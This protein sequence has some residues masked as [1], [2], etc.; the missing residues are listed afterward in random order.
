M[1]NPKLATLVDPFTGAS[2][3]TG[4]WSNITG[5]TATLD[6]TNDLVVLAQ[7]TV[8]GTTNTFGSNTLYDATASSI[9][10]EVGTVANGSGQ[11][12]TIFKILL[13]ANNSVAM[14][15][16]AGVFKFTMQIAGVTTTTTLPT[17]DP[18]AHGWWRLRES[19]GSFFADVSSDGFTW[20][21]LTSSTYSWSAVAVTFVFQTS[22]GGT[23]VAGNS[24]TIQHVNTMLGGG[25]AT[26]WNINWPLLEEAWAPQWNAAGGASPLDRYVDVTDRTRQQSTVSRG[27]Q[28]EL[29]QVR[30]GEA[31]LE[32]ENLDGV[33]DPTNSSGP[34]FNSI[35]PFQP[36]RKRAQWPRTRNLL[37]QMQATAGDL[38]GQTVGATAGSNSSDVF[39]T[40][41]SG[42]GTIVSTASAWQG[43]TVY[44]FAVTSAAT[45][46]QGICYTMQPAVEPGIQYTVSLWVRNV[47]AS[48]SLQ[49]QAFQ[50]SVAIGGARTNTT[51]TATTLTG[52][53]TA[54]WTQVTVT[55]TATST[56]SSLILG[57]QVVTAPGSTAQ[58]QVDGWQLEKAATASTWACPGVWYP[59]FAGFMER[60]PSQ[61]A[62]SG[63]YGTVQP[64][65]VDAMALLS[66]VTLKDPLAQQ[67]NG[68][69][70][71]FLYT[72][73]DPQSSSYA[74][75]STGQYGPAP[76]A[77][78][79]Y[80]SGSVVFGTQI[81]S[82][83]AGGTY[84]GASGTVATVNN[85]NPGSGAINAATW[86]S[87]SGAGVKGPAN[88]SLW[89]RMIA[90]RY[91]GPTPG[92]GGNFATIWT[93]MDGQRA[94][95]Q[96]S[97]SQ[98]W[99]YIDSTGR[100]NFQLRGPTGT[101]QTWLFGS[102]AN[103]VDSNWHLL[104]FGY[105]AA[106][107]EMLMSLDGGLACYAGGL[108]AGLAPTGLISDCVGAYVDPTDGNGTAGNFKGDLSYA[109]E[110]PIEFQSADIT[111]MY[112]AWKSS[113]TGDSTNARYAR[114]LSYAGYTGL[115]SLQ[116][117][118][119]TS[120]GPMATGG[121]DGLSALQAV[122]DTENGEHYVARDGTV[123]FKARSA[124]YNATVPA[125]VFGE[126]TDLGEIPY[127]DC[128]LDFDSTHLANL[129]QVTQ[130]STNQVFTAQDSTSQTNYFPRTLTRSINPS[131]ALEC[132]D[133][134]NYLVSRYKNP[135]TRVS[136][137]VLHPSANPQ[138]W[139]MCLSLELGMRVR[140]NRR[141]PSPAA[142]ISVDCFVENLQWSNDSQGEAQLT[143]QCSPIDSTPY[144]ILAA[145][146]TT[147]NTTVLSGVNTITINNSADNTNK[148]AAQIYPGLQ[149]MFSPGFSTQE[150]LTV[151]SVG[152]TSPGWTTATIVF[153]TNLA[154]GHISGETICEVLP[155]GVTDATTYDNNAK[156]DSIAFAY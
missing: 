57:V 131:S 142:A 15:L 95:N 62:M 79:K 4:L 117:G 150:T 90:V 145:W 65:A 31:S 139:P 6:Q 13:D 86:V 8:S 120:M 18:N 143:L 125:Y 52:S 140:V 80:G 32:L 108:P 51:G 84:I 22:A 49:V 23:E 128:Q 102:P 40:T 45:A 48:T 27:R 137:L 82:A 91:T 71:A 72:L 141:P 118:V 153:T 103:I 28:Y 146:H 132:Q 68:N 1:P 101:T 152:A 14:R 69:K 16:E 88:P 54:A 147:L 58:I 10:A 154:H 11:T 126:R 85:P 107:N 60:W 92:A 109:V 116:T 100:P 46:G 112:S 97:G 66:Q 83:S 20:T 127:E 94:S 124:R 67:I 78:S 19:S 76:L 113:F 106:A 77:N 59:M 104:I 2:I 38:G 42:G 9:Y 129:A 7:P 96:P 121:Q 151:Q 55:A 149:L 110:F 148:L 155:A 3:N 98:I 114:I 130:S 26:T 64:T 105:N 24:A 25:P 44:Q 75:D 47:T 61:W 123:T 93:A 87:L 29:D 111:A 115:S 37:S 156:L 70:P 89:T 33:L 12:K 36:Y 136:S 53:A 134:A 138:V 135:L 56:A 133:A 34:Y 119:T 5:G 99:I 41:D 73:G 39:S 74:T 17:Y 35:R 122:V 63:T 21:N 81:T 144:G 30:A 43:G 50:A